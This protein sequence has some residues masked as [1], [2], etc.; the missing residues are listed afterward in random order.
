MVRGAPVL[1]VRSDPD[2]VEQALRAGG[3]ACPRLGCGGVLGPWGWTQGRWLR[4]RGGICQRIHLRRSRCRACRATHVLLPVTGLRR[5]LDIAEVIGAALLARATGRS[6]RQV[7]AWLDVPLSTG[8]GLDP[9]VCRPG[10]ADHR[11]FHQAGGL[12]G[13]GVPVGAPRGSPLEQALEAIGA[14]AVVATRRLGVHA[15]PFVFASGASG[16]RLLCNTTAP[17]PA[18]W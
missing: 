18:P 16:G 3:L 10:S 6:L 5:R 8:A 4:G 15:G 7:A 9:P 12:A 13:P 14:A 2:R 1:M 17:F 11:T